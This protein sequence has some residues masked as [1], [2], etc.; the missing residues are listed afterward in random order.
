VGLG[1]FM[2]RKARESID[3]SKAV[4]LL[5]RLV[6]IYSELGP[7]WKL[8]EGDENEE[9][10]EGEED[11]YSLTVN[12]LE[13]K[14]GQLYQITP[15]PFHER[16]LQ[17]IKD[18]NLAYTGYK[19]TRKM[20]PRESEIGD[21]VFEDIKAVAEYLRNSWER[22]HEI[23]E[24]V[25]KTFPPV[26]FDFRP[27]ISELSKEYLHYLTVESLEKAISYFDKENY[28]DCIL[29]CCNAGE[30]LTEEIV[31]HL[32]LSKE[33]N[34]R[35][36]LDKIQKHL[37]DKNLKSI[38]IHWFIYYLLNVVYFTRNP[39]PTEAKN[40]PVWMD[41]YKK[42]ELATPKWARIALICSLE[43]SQNFQKVLESEQIQS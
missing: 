10:S 34:W 27:Q 11:G 17:L 9:Y 35:R 36:N 31:T 37:K 14:L 28:T 42:K 33:G 19:K 24:R 15:G 18:T 30:K 22:L 2:S 39:H 29:Y 40:I 21:K 20:V 16:I 32:N 1:D 3:E 25:L 26:H 38:H 8:N 4:D 43:A 23:E 41:K 12:E 5:L 13:F 7:V 6:K